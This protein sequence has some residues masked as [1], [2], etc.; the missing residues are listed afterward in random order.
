M[1]QQITK[2]ITVSLLPSELGDLKKN[3]YQHL[4]DEIK[5]TK[6]LDIL[7]AK[8][9]SI[10][11]HEA[12]IS[13]VSEYIYV[14]TTVQIE[15]EMLIRD[16]EFEAIIIAINST[17]IMVQT[18]CNFLVL[19]SEADLVSGGFVFMT[20]KNMF[21]HSQHKASF[22]TSDKCRVKLTHIDTEYILGVFL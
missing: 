17:G 19:I 1:K 18:A 21:K 22:Q 10:L 15:Q 13:A 11:T 14:N 7:S 9:V 20:R 2:T 16:M 5:K 8:I 3:L 6:T 4:E 12:T